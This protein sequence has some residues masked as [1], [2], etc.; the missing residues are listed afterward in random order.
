[1]LEVSGSMLAEPAVERSVSAS[2]NPAA[3]RGGWRVLTALGFGYIGVYLCRKNLAVAVPLLQTAFSAT[4]EQVG[5]IASAGTFAYAI[6]KLVNGVVVDRIGGRRG[7][8]LS[9]VAVAFC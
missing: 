6:G 3:V 5:S 1:M 4:K 7:F 8:L 2:E 9:L